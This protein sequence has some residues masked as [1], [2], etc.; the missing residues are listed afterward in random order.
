MMNKELRKNF[1]LQIAIVRTIG[2]AIGL[3]KATG[4]SNNDL[5]EIEGAFNLICDEFLEMHE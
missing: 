3:L 1:K 5:S 4:I 2:Q